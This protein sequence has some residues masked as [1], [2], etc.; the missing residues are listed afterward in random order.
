[1]NTLD[2]IARRL[3]L[4]G[5]SAPAK[6]A[7]APS[8]PAKLAALVRALSTA[9]DKLP[10]PPPPMPPVRHPPQLTSIAVQ[11]D[12]NGKIAAVTV[13]ATNGSRHHL[14]ARR[15]DLGR[16]HSITVDDRTTWKV[17][18]GYNDQIAGLVP[19]ADVSD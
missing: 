16:M 18:R 4:Q 6:P 15:D 7:P 1:M 2:R 9:A 11:R 12:S 8:K 10:P 19:V 17:Q 3:A 13:A 5:A 14:V